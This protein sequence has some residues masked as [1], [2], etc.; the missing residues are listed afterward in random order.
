MNL[1]YN[2]NEDEFNRLLSQLI[3]KSDETKLGG[4][5]GKIESHHK[6]GKLTARER[7]DFLRD[8]RSDF[9]EIGLLAGD[10]MYT[11]IGGCPSG[12]GGLRY[13]LHQ[14]KTVRNRS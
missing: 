4:G 10:G 9:L 11:D 14:R 8:P 13:W 7:V 1:E 2:K 12:G 5:K 6:K 3:V